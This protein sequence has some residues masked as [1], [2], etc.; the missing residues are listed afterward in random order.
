VTST[1]PRPQRTAAEAAAYARSM[2]GRG[3][4]R[5]GTGNHH[6]KGDDERD[7]WGFAFCECYLVP[8]HR[9]RFN[10]DRWRDADGRTASVVDD[11]N[12]NS[13]IEDADH[14]GE[15]LRRVHIPMVGDLIAYPTIIMA[16]D[17]YG[18]VK[19]VI[20]LDRL[21]HAVW[22]PSKPDW[23]LLDTVECCG[24]NGHRPGIVLGNGAAMN[25]RDRRVKDPRDRTALL[26][27]RA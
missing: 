1:G 5:W 11:L 15:L 7:C 17:R 4:Y 8:R 20:G 19:I 22:D 16:G 18:H 25:D 13:G 3:V 9:P 27:V 24:P 6:S 26:R 21:A 10:A 12:C 14:A 2:V 23:S